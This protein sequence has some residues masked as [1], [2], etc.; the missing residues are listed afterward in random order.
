MIF[1]VG[2]GLQGCGYCFIPRGCPAR[3]IDAVLKRSIGGWLM[4][5]AYC[6]TPLHPYASAHPYFHP[7]VVPRGTSTLL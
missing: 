4:V 7:S 2:S 5:G 1:A 3:G 6:N